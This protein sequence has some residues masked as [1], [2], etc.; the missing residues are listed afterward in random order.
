MFRHTSKRRLLWA[1]ASTLIGQETHYPPSAAL[2]R[3]RH[4][5]YSNKVVAASAVALWCNG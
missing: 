4:F 2:V 1:L 3:A 5:P